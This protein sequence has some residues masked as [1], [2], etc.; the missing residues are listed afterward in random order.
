MV[1]S[2]VYDF[3]KDY[4]DKFLFDFDRSQ[5]TMSVLSGMAIF[6]LSR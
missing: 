2:Y 1:S 4:L 3:F 6:A 5:L